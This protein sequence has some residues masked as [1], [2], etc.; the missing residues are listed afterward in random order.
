MLLH[1]CII[2]TGFSGIPTLCQA[3]CWCG[4]RAVNESTGPI[5]PKPLR[6]TEKSTAN[7]DSVMSVHIGEDVMD[8][9]VGDPSSPKAVEEVLQGSIT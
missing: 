7:G 3:L 4:D 5:L 2:S 1:S 8:V 6:K 9:T